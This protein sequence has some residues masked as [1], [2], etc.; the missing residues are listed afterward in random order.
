MWLLFQ[1]KLSDDF[2]PTN[3]GEAQRPGIP[4]TAWEKDLWTKYKAGCFIPHHTKNVGRSEV[5]KERREGKQTHAPP[6][7]SPVKYNTFCG[8]TLDA[9]EFLF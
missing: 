2:Q 9:F 3:Y 8:N 7:F 1:C 5:R 4:G 6:S